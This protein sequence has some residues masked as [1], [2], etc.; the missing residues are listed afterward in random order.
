MT[1]RH[2]GPR[3]K[4]NRLFYV[5]V[6]LGRTGSMLVQVRANSKREATAQGKSKGLDEVSSEARK[7]VR[8]TSVKEVDLCA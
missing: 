4:A 3:S 8:V 6:R 5:V 7:D 2:H 1:R